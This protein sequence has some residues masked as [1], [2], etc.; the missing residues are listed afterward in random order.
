[1]AKEEPKSE[2]ARHLG[3]LDA[4]NIVIGSMIGSGIFIA[5]SLMAG[6]IQTPGI[7]VLLWLIGGILTVFASLLFN[8]M[9]VIGLVK[10]RR[11]G[12]VP[13]PDRIA[14]LFLLEKKAGA[15]TGRRVNRQPGQSS[16]ELFL[17]DIFLLFL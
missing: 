12:G 2:M 11:Q 5:P 3:V 7:L 4:G 14:G 10:L 15:G 1:M 8:A 16:I 9:T 13:D 17:I 6:Y